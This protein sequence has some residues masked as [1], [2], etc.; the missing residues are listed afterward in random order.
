MQALTAE[1][2]MQRTQA[3]EDKSEISRLRNE[4]TD[5][6]TKYYECRRKAAAQS[7]YVSP[8]LSRLAID[9]CNVST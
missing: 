9:T 7:L 8:S 3:E 2:N 1:M 4:V 5:W 6:K